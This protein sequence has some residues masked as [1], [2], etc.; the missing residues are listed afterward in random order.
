MYVRNSSLRAML[1]GVMN[2]LE[3][4]DPLLVDSHNVG[5]SV[6]LRAISALPSRSVLMRVIETRGTVRVLGRVVLWADDVF[7]LWKSHPGE[8]EPLGPGAFMRV[9]SDRGVT[10]TDRALDLQA[11]KVLCAAIDDLCREWVGEWAGHSKVEIEEALRLAES[12]PERALVEI[13]ANP[14]DGSTVK[15]L[16][17]LGYDRDHSVVNCARVLLG[18][19]EHA[20]FAFDLPTKAVSILAQRAESLRRTLAA[21]GDPPVT[22]VPLAVGLVGS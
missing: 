3:P 14:R 21:G 20:Q 11:G 2:E 17:R 4:L 5:V 9:G 18:L 7:P 19:G 12:L 22:P 15:E 8:G 16:T 13:V 1:V 10:W 6:A